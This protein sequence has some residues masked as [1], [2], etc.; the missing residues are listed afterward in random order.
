MGHGQ[1]RREALV[2]FD[3]PHPGQLVLQGVQSIQNLA[4]LKA[5]LPGERPWHPDYDLEDVLVPD[6]TPEVACEMRARHDLEGTGDHPLA[7]GERY[8]GAYFSQIEGSD[9]P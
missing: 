6:Q 1:P 7:V 9:P 4:S 3:E 5:D 2:P 8:A